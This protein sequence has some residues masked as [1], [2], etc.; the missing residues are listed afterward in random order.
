MQDEGDWT[1]ASAQGRR[2]SLPLVP[3]VLLTKRYEALGVE[4]EEDLDSGSEPERDNQTKTVQ[5]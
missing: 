3:E 2:I 1:F 4:R 5:P